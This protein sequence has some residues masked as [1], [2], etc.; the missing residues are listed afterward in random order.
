MNDLFTVHNL[1]SLLRLILLHAVL[2]FSN[3][4]RGLLMMARTDKWAH[5]EFFRNPFEPI[6][7]ATLYFVIIVFVIV[8][9]IQGK[10]K[11][12]IVILEQ[13][14]EEGNGSS[15]KAHE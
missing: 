6:R 2:G 11:K 15:N 13:K 1:L 9:S 12:K 14:E 7:Q 8:D 3:A 5:I 10:Y 4:A